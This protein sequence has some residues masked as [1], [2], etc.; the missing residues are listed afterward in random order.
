GRIQ[1]LFRKGG[2]STTVWIDHPGAV[3]APPAAPAEV[4]AAVRA[5]LARPR[6]V[7]PWV[8]VTERPRPATPPDELPRR[9]AFITLLLLAAALA[10]AWVS[11]LRGLWQRTSGLSRLWWL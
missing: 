11:V 2:A 8:R 3:R 7:L 4:V 6:A 9:F 1:L 10:W 5:A